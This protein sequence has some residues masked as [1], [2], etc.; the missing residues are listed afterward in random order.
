MAR[1]IA[2]PKSVEA[3]ALLDVNASPW[4]HVRVDDIARGETPLLGLSLAPGTHKIEL[5][6]EPLGVHRE[7]TVTL[8]SGEHATRVEDLTR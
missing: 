5:A 1:P 7:L 4:A 8:H 6:N 3:P 2:A